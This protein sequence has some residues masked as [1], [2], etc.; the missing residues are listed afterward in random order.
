MELAM[1]APRWY[2]IDFRK[3]GKWAGEYGANLWSMHLLF[4]GKKPTLISKVNPE[5]YK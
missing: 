2:E 5:L 3:I 1:D 4:A